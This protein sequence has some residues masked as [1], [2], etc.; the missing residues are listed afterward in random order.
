MAKAYSWENSGYESPASGGGGLGYGF[1]VLLSVIIGVSLFAGILLGL[2]E[3]KVLLG[4]TETLEIKSK[5]FQV[6]QIELAAQDPPEVEE[7]IIVPENTD[8]SE[9]LAEVEELI[10][11]LDDT[12]LDISPEIAQ[13]EVTLESSLALAAGEELG[14]LLE[15]VAAPKVDHVLDQVGRAE[16]LFQEAAAGQIMVEEGSVKA[17]LV[18]PDEL[19][20][21][22]AS[23]GSGG[24]SEEGLPSG[25]ASIDGLLKMAT[26]ELSRSRAALPSDLLFEYDSAQLRETA[27][28]GL[29]KLA[30]LID[31][32]PQMYCVLEGH[33]DLYGPDSY[34]RNLSRQRAQAVKDWLV[35]SMRLEGDRIIVRA[36]GSSQPKVLEGSIEEQ[37]INRRVDILMR[38]EIP[39]EVTL[40]APVQPVPARRDP[41]E[42]PPLRALR[43]EEEP[44]PAAEEQPLKALPVE[45]EPEQKPLRALPVEEGTPQRALPVEEQK[46][47]KALPV[48]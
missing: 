16:N 6:E 29:M 34:N 13:P 28:L 46:P 32:N 48:E 40:P 23:Q 8:A 30:M 47:L 43:V 35:Q 39:E 12:E 15:P 18:D 11:E 38:K 36:Y 41:V 27:R 3:L 4:M 7:E 9:L 17:D 20:K 24:L 31:R 19:L 14:E 21:D 5:P 37:A 42:A 2:S 22:M 33:T 10:P 25:Y 1:A 44:A 45:E 26:G